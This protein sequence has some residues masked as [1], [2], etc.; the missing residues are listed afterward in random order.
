MRKT[1]ETVVSAL[2]D[3]K[4]KAVKSTATDGK[5]LW[6][7]GYPIAWRNNFA[8]QDAN[9]RFTLAGWNT[10]TTRDRLNTLFTLLNLPIRVLSKKFEPHVY[11]FYT[12]Q[13]AP[14]DAYAIYSAADFMQ[15]E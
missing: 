6:L 11:N 5:T 12:K 9:W 10:A 4:P 1:S 13:M 2:L 3:G 8:P 14:I 15:P 7:H